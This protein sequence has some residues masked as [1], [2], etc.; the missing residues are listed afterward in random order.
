M[1]QRAVDEDAQEAALKVL[2]WVLKVS[3]EKNCSP[4]IL[5][6]RCG[7]PE[8]DSMQSVAKNGVTRAAIS[9]FA[10]VRGLRLNAEPE[11]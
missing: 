11:V 8:E 3:A 10:T 1:P 4:K 9:K 2:F 6:L 7:G 5:R